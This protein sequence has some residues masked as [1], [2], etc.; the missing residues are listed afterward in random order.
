MINGGARQKIQIA[1]T[2]LVLDQPFFGVL[3]LR[4]TVV[5][6]P[7]CGTAWTDGQSI[8]YD[9]AFVNRLSADEI[10]AL[11]A[12]EIMHV[13]CGHPWRRSGRD[14]ERFNL[15]CDLA[16]N[17]IV[18][19][20]GFRLPAGAI[21]DRS[22]AGKSAEWIY[23]RLP[24]QAKGDGTGVGAATGG[25][26]GGKGTAGGAWKVAPTAGQGSPEADP[27]PTADPGPA[28]GGC[29]VRD[30]PPDDGSGSTEA[31]WQQAVQQAAAAAHGRGKL[32]ASLARL[33]TA[34]AAPKVDWRSVLHRFV[35]QVARDDYSWRTPNPRYLAGGLY[36]PALRSDAIGPIAVAI[37]TSG[38]IDTVLLDQFAAEL[39]SVVD[40]VLPTR[41]HVIYCDAKV[42]RIDTF[43]RGDVLELHPAGGGGTDFRPALAAAETFDEVPACCIYLTDLAGRF[44]DAA[45]SIPVLWA[46][47]VDRP[48]PFG[49]VVVL[50]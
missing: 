27:S 49:E 13:A 45:P 32:P 20:A 7:G 12:H 21:V 42:Q 11:I 26:G 25:Q 10:T 44:P 29:D 48:V 30:A 43:E 5:E 22:L 38:S 14:N 18:Q 50:E 47:T 40:D 1:R 23:A 33:A 28:R 17:P 6:D 36:L 8:G 35:Q 16:I 19:D 39:R 4:L 9:P 41:V 34:A 37:D 2:A 3:A 31:D 15:A 46:T 24:D